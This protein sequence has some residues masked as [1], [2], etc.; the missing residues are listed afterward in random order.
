MILSDGKTIKPILIPHSFHANK[1]A[2]LD[3]NEL[4]NVCILAIKTRKTSE[5]TGRIFRNQMI[6]PSV[7]H[8]SSSLRL[9]RSPAIRANAAKLAALARCYAGGGNKPSLPAL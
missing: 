6:K 2:C 4:K 7:L 3:A 9:F 1:A 5:W 8:L